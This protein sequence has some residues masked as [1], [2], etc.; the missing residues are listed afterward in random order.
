MI[1]HLFPNFIAGYD[2]AGSSSNK[3]C[4]DQEPDRNMKAEDWKH[5]EKIKR[6]QWFTYW[7]GRAR[8]TL[9]TL[10]FTAEP[11]ISN[12]QLNSAVT[13]EKLALSKG[14]RVAFVVSIQGGPVS[15]AEFHEIP[16]MMR[17]TI[18]DISSR[19]VDGE[20]ALFWLH[21]QNISDLIKALQGYGGI[22]IYDYWQ[23]RRPFNLPGEWRDGEYNQKYDLLRSLPGA[24]PEDRR[25]KLLAAVDTT[26]PSKRL[27]AAIE[28]GSATAVQH[29][30][31]KR[32]D[33][34]A[35]SSHDRKHC[36]AIAAINANV[37]VVHVLLD[38]KADARAKDREGL[39]PLDRL[40]YFSKDWPLKV[41]EVKATYDAL[42]EVLTK[43]SK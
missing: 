19:H 33:P 2:F 28:S 38:A 25:Q 40:K 16:A 29:A 9:T 36:L 22:D 26:D 18:A 6:S 30:L 23:N 24:K 35:E 20:W 43:P 17:G 11:L 3:E 10:L 12:I 27:L 42:V 1:D 39:I 4:A 37:D 15:N 31:S 34:T 14:E 5:A 8:A 41:P 13:D 7:M 32:A 21:F